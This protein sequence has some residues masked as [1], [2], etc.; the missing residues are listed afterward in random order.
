MIQTLEELS[1]LPGISG[2]E[3]AVREY[4]CKRLEGHCDYSV[5]PL[6]NIIVFKKGL[7]PAI[8]KLLFSA[9]MDEIGFVVTGI[10]KDGYLHFAKVGGIDDRVIF[11][12]V[13][14]IGPNGIPG[15]IAGKPVHL[16]KDSELTDPPPANKLLIDIGAKSK[17][18]AE[19]LVQ[20]GDAVVYYG[21]F[22]RMGEHTIIG[23][24]FDDRAGCA[25]LLNMIEGEIPY[26]CWFSFTVQEEI[27]CVGGEAAAYTVNP[28]IG[29]V[30]EST[31][32]S[33]IGGVDEDCKV[34]YQG[35]GPVLSFK[36]RGAIYDIKI[37]HRIL[38]LAEQKNIPCQSKLG[39]FGGNEARA[40]QTS[41]G[42]SRIVAVSL[43]TR[44]L[45][46]P[47]NT[48]DVRDIDSTRKL[49]EEI[50]ADLAPANGKDFE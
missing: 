37:Y 38:K 36:D 19:K 12:K 35:M 43:P 18:E 8:K 4:L 42:G 17:E 46:S 44:Y 10:H 29:I 16:V 33:D 49:L 45:H 24:A 48:L 31:T 14:Q 3:H 30:V 9:H 20:P 50:L 25:M 34:C 26:D 23:K 39:A 7:K 6:G 2:Q 1:Q 40:I 32:A 27:G 15:V 11:G 5:D 22:D 28:D 13:V 47:S 41:R 21:P